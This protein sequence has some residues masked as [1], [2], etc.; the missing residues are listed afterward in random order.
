MKNKKLKRTKKSKK[1]QKQRNPKNNEKTK[2]LEAK[3]PRSQKEGVDSK[4]K[5]RLLKKICRG[6]ST[7]NLTLG[8]I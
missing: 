2:I 6:Y 8:V 7:K 5:K 3:R 4:N 1:F